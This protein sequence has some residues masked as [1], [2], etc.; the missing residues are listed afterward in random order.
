AAALCAS[1]YGKKPAP[2]AAQP[3]PAAAAASGEK[4]E[5]QEQRGIADDVSD[6]ADYA[7]GK[8][9]I[10]QGKQIKRRFRKIQDEHNRKLEEAM[11]E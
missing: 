6:F 11:G 9:P 5:V 10:E 4:D 2:R 7:T 3:G 1:S 8:K